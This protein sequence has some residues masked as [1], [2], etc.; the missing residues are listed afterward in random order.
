MRALSQTF[1]ANLLNQDGLLRPILERT[2]Q[3]HTLMVSIR[4]GYINIYYRGGN[5]LRVK[6]HHSGS[7]NAFFDNEYNKYGLPCPVLPGTIETQESAKSWVESFQA[8][9][10]IM[11]KDQNGCR[12]QA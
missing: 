9:K 8:L 7:Y 11:D 5:I 10:G 4:E 12:S 3:D 1:M 2:K 6:E